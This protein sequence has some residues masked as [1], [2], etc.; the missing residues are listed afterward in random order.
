MVEHRT[1]NAGVAGSIPALATSLRSREAAPKRELRLGEPG[2]G[3]PAEAR[4]AKADLR[5]TSP[6]P[7]E[8]QEFHVIRVIPL[9]ALLCIA[10]ACSRGPTKGTTVEPVSGVTATQA[11]TGADAVKP[12]PEKLPDV[13]ARVNGETVTRSELEQYVQNMERQAGGTLPPDERDR[14][15]RGVI[16]QLVGYKL[17]MQEANSRK[18]D[19][20]EA[21]INAR[22]E[23]VKKQFPSEDLFMQTLIERKMTL[24]QLKADARKD[25]AIA[26]LIENEIASKVAVRPGQAEDFYAKNPD[27]FKQP[28]RVKASH[29]LISIPQN[30]DA[31]AKAQAKAK[32]Q[33]VLKDLKAG[34]D[35]AALAK[36]H[37]QDPGSADNGGDLGFFQ[38]G[39]M[40]GPFNDVAFSLKP[41]VLSDLVETEFGFHIIKVAEKQPG[42]TVPLE[43]VRPQLEQYLQNQNRESETEAFV[44]ALRAKG[45]VE[46]LI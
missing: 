14:I 16:D 8:V 37:S 3:C 30:A 4:S 6:K 39:Q 5:E 34:K 13:L 35:F 10:F 42:R 18:V 2:E 17:L 44:K 25:I 28:E 29:I 33:Q 41:G 43:E 27:Q 40:V 21:D 9:I 24:D 7:Y 46:I 11:G 31:A 19:V 26:K 12:L 15:Y 1:E 20:P 38:Q 36:Q 22:I 23:Q 32:A 45:K